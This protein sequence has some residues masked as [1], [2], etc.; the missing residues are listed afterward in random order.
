MKKV[1]TPKNS[2][3]DIGATHIDMYNWPQFVTPQ[4]RSS[5][6]SLVAMLHGVKDWERLDGSW[7]LISRLWRSS[8]GRHLTTMGSK[9]P[10]ADA[11]HWQWSPYS[12]GRKVAFAS[13]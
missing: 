2:N 6:T 1:K 10:F 13:T 12:L 5:P 8:E 4:F 11:L 3:V 9:L 7:N